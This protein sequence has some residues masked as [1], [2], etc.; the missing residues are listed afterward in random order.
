MEL[1]FS[2]FPTIETLTAQTLAG[3]LVFGFYFTV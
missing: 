3:L 2:V 1:W